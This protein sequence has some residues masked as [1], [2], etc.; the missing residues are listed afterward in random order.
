MGTVKCKFDFERVMPRY[1]R[2]LD[3]TCQAFLKSNVVFDSIRGFSD[4]CDGEHICQVDR[5]IFQ[6]LKITSLVLVL[7]KIMV[8]FEN[9]SLHIAVLTKNE[10][11]NSRNNL[12]RHDFY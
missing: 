11:I 1:S 6:Y 9:I 8:I 10:W 2:M 5:Q 3:F 12:E 4:N 7:K